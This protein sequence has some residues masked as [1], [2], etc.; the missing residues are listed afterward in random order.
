MQIVPRHKNLPTM[1]L[2]TKS[3]SISAE[4]HNPMQ[5]LLTLAGASGVQ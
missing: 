2:L 3:L 5:I 4:A 1:T